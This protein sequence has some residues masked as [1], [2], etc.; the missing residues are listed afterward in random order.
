M[1]PIASPRLV[2]FS[3]RVLAGFIA[4]NSL[5]VFLPLTWIDSVLSWSGV[6]HVPD[7]MLFQ[8]LLRG[9]G[10]LLLAI[11]VL[12]WMIAADVV[13]YQPLVIVVGMLFL[14][15]APVSWLIDAF[16]GLPLWWRLLDAAICVLG[17]GVP[18]LFCVWP[19]KAS[20]NHAPQ[21]RQARSS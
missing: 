7:E 9:A 2:A 8:Y 18:V 5:S 15:G 20:S 4:L 13:R 14:V 12:I 6:G 19:M 1:K 11:A 16:V 3:L 21:P 10:V 17:G